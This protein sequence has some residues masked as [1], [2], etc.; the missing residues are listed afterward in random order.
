MKAIFKTK[1]LVEL[2]LDS[3]RKEK[4]FYR[5]Y[6]GINDSLREIIIMKIYATAG[7]SYACFWIEDKEHG[8]F[9]SGG[10]K[11]G[12]K[13]SMGNHKASAAAQNA[14]NAAGIFLDHGIDTYG[15]G[16]IKHAMSAI[17]SELSYHKHAIV[18]ALP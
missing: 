18:E 1:N 17:M 10:G 7:T 14:I 11:S 5:Q 16:A 4:H 15:D 2:E 6:T 3:Y 13:G 8:I 9:S 12:G